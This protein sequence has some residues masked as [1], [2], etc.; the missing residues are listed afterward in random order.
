MSAEIR[1]FLQGEELTEEGEEHAEEGEDSH[2]EDD[3][4][5]TNPILPTGWE[6][7][8]AALFFAIL[9]IAMRL[10]LVP[11]LRKTMSERDATIREAKAAADIVDTDLGTA[12]DDYE[13][14]LAAA[15]DEANGYIEAARAEADGYRA[16]LQATAD[17]EIAE[18]RS[19]ADGEIEAARASALQELRGDVS[20]LAVGAASA[21][22]GRSVDAGANQS[23]IDRALGGPS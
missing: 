6:I 12:R 13:T 20:Q 4:G 22:L 16:E 1:L 17:R 21:V 2:A 8:W 14:A 18:L 23:V 19:V 9:F 7:V 10:V 5:T 15:R 3:A 11:P